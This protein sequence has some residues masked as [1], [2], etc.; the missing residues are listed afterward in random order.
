MAARKPTNTT[1]RKSK[2]KAKAQSSAAKPALEA[3]QPSPAE[4]PKRPRGRPSLYT[5]ELA[6]QICHALAS[7]FSLNEICQADDMPDEVTVRGWAL[8]DREGFAAKY[9][10]AREIQAHRW[11]D[12]IIDIGDDGRNDWVLRQNPD[13]G[14]E[15][16]VLNGEHI[17]RSKQRCENR[18]WLLSKLLPK[19]FGDKLELTGD[20]LNKL[21]A[22]DIEN[23]LAAL[24]AAVEKR[25]TA[26]QPEPSNG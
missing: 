19:Q 3:A 4:K 13:T 11:A 1:T 6:A 20:A 23:K 17:Q 7:G 5:P 15:Y 18:K 10:R 14:R 16:F 9:A 26:A 24:M 25:Q 21:P 12:E 8:D 22:Q 2:A